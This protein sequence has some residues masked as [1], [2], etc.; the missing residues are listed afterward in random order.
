MGWERNHFDRSVHFLFGLPLAYPIRELYCW[1]ADSKGFWSYFFPLELTMAASMMF[2][3]FEWGAAEMFGGDLGIAYLG[4]QGDI[5]DA[6]KHMALASLGAF[7]AMGITLILNLRIQKDFREEWVASLS[8]KHHRPLGEDEIVRLVKGEDRWPV[9]FC[10]L[11]KDDNMPWV[12][13]I[14][15]EKDDTPNE[16]VQQLYKKT[17]NTV[18]GKISDL[19]RLTSLTP[20]VSKH[21]DSLCSAIYK[22]ASGLTVREK[23][24]A[25][26]VTSSFI[27][28]VHWIASHLEALG[29]VARNKEFAKQVAE[30]YTKAGLNARE[31]RIADTAVKITRSPDACSP[32]DIKIL[33]KE[34][35]SDVDIVSLIELVAY[36]NMSTRIMESLSTI[37]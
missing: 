9:K 33:R 19:T 37:E 10:I 26:L 7:L 29:R 23:E 25:A 8:V 24:I 34:G 21:I 30:D 35:F 1:I 3:L 14:Q 20:E 12:P 16:E 4:T 36:Q 27:G 6:H 2:E 18:T 22:N 13:W 32:A 5:W 15:I 28:C 17:R 11:R 31:R